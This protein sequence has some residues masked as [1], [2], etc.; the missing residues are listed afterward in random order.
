M[1]TRRSHSVVGRVLGGPPYGEVKA[2]SSDPKKD[3]ALRYHSLHDN[4]YLRYFVGHADQVV[5]VSMSAK[6]DQFLSA[7]RD[8]TVRLWDL[9]T[10]NCNGVVHCRTTP[11]VAH[12]LQGLIFAAATDDGE[13]KLYDARGGAGW[14]G[15]RRESHG[16][17]GQ[18]G[19]GVKGGQRGVKW[20]KMMGRRC[21]INGIWG[22]STG[23]A[24]V[25]G[26]S[27]HLSLDTK[28]PWN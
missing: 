5:S 15:H 3:H 18:T 8:K 6:S 14:E 1:K 26:R 13:V 16:G 12:D 11:C 19:W 28:D 20:V 17:V 4:K 21:G 2:A 22:R 7:S 9:R 23:M 24:L 10:N 27:G 25:V